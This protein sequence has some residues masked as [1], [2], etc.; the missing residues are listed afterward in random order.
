MGMKLNHAVKL[1]LEGI[2]D[3]RPKEAIDKYT[4]DRYTQH[5]T[6]VPDGKD[7]FVA[8]FENFIQRYPVRDIHIIRVFEDGQYVFMHCYQNLNNGAA[9]YVT[10]DFFD[11]DDDDKMIEHW[12][13]IAEFMPRTPSGHTSIDGL[14]IVTDLDKTQDNKELVRG[15]IEEVFIPSAVEKVERYI[16][17]DWFI[18]H[19]IGIPDGLEHYKPLVLTG[20]RPLDYNELVL[21]VGQGNFVATLCKAAWQG[22][23]YAQADLFR[24]EDGKIVEHWAV[25]EPV[26]PKDELVNSGKF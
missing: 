22:Q 24:V 12:D 4:G 6:G 2:Q 11:T 10:M 15:L 7:G 18:Q 26:P 17:K 8:F 5:S 23:P 19:G 25:A 3:G 9:Q 20:D 13:V 16:N 1:L 21:L 14:S